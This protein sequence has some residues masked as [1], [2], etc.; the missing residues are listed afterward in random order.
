MDKPGPALYLGVR[1]GQI[2]QPLILYF[3]QV[4]SGFPSLNV[5]LSKSV[6]DDH[7]SVFEIVLVVRVGQALSVASKCGQV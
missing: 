6:Q 5:A 3:C 4:V 7:P 1:I 2:H